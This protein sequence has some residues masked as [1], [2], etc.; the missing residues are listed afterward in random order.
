MGIVA[1]I[2][3]L[4]SYP[5]HATS[6]LFQYDPVKEEEQRQAALNLKLEA[7]EQQIYQRLYAQSKS[8][9]SSFASSYF[10]SLIEN[11]KVINPTFLLQNNY[12]SSLTKLNNS[13]VV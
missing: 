4:P 12:I 2:R 11:L 3:F 8:W 13:I 10:T 6:C 7:L 9:L 5:M 1:L